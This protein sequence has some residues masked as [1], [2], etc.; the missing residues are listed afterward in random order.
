V[1][2][3][4]RN[5]GKIRLADR[6]A[7]T[8]DELQASSYSNRRAMYELRDNLHGRRY[9][10]SLV[11]AGQHNSHS[12]VL[13]TIPRRTVVRVMGARSDAVLLLQDLA[14][15]DPVMLR[16]MRN[17]QRVADCAVSVLI[18]GPTGSGKETFAK[19]IHLASNRR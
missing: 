11:G 17:A 7:A 3:C 2:H 8:F 14:G 6:L 12:R 16:N 10:A 4:E 19:A 1:I 9:F 18:R 15:E 13:P 5:V